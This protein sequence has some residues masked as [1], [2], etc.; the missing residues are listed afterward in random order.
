MNLLLQQDKENMKKPLL[1]LLTLVMCLSV[2]G[3][4]PLETALKHLEKNHERFDLTEG[5]VQ[6]LIV[7]DNYTSKHN[8]VQHIYLQQQ[9]KGI[10]VH[11]AIVNINVTESGKVLNTGNRFV[12]HL[13]KKINTDLPT[14]SASQAVQAAAR[15]LELNFADAIN[16]EK[17][18]EGLTQKTVL[19][20]PDL[21][22]DPIPAELVYQPFEEDNSVR[23]AWNLLI[24]T[25][26]YKDAWNVR[27]DAMTGEL[28]DKYNQVIHCNFGT[29]DPSCIEHGHHHFPPVSTTSTA[30]SVP[31]DY[32][33]YAFPIE[34]PIHGERSIVNSPWEA[35]GPDASP[36]GWHSDGNADFTTTRGNNV[37]AQEDR[38]GND[39]FGYSPE[40]P[41]LDFN[42]PLD[43]NLPPSEYQDAAITNLF[44]WCN[45]MHDVWYQYGFDEPSGNFQANNRDQ[46]G[47][48]VDAIQADAQDGSGTNNANFQSGGDG[49]F[50]RI[51]MFEWSN[52]NIVPP[53]NISF[54]PIISGTYNGSLAGFDPPLPLDPLEGDVVVAY[55]AS[56][57]PTWCCE[58]IANADEVAGNIALI[59][60]GD[61]WFVEK[62][63]NA[64]DAGAIAVIIYNNEPGNGTIPLGAPDGFAND[65]NIPAIMIGNNDAQDILEAIDLGLPV[66]VSLQGTPHSN[67]PNLDGDLD[68]GIISHEY[69]HGL[70]IRMTGGPSSGGC[71]G[72]EEQMGE[73]WSDWFGLM[74]TMT[75]EHDRNTPRGYGTYASSQSIDGTG[76]REAPYTT[77]FAINNYTYGATNNPNL[78]VP[79]SIGFV[80]ATIL[81]EAT[82]DMIDMYGFDPDLHN[83][84]GGNNI[85]M[86]LVIDGIKL[87]PCSPGFIDGRDA[88]LLA[89]EINYGGEHVCMLWEAFA[90]RG[91]GGSASQGNSSSRFDQTEAFDIGAACVPNIRLSME[92]S[93]DS[94]NAG[95]NI[96]YTFTVTNEALQAVTGTHIDVRIPDN[97]T[98]VEGSSEYP[99]TVND[100]MVTLTI[101]DMADGAVAVCNMELTADPSV[102]TSVLLMDPMETDENW[103]TS[104]GGFSSE[105]FTL[106][107]DN[108][109]TGEFAWFARDIETQ[110]DQYLEINEPLSIGSNLA[111]PVLSFWHDYDTEA[112]WDGG[113]VEYST[114]GNNWIDMGQYMVQNGYNSVIQT[115]PDSEISDREAFSGQSDGYINTLIDVSSFAGQNIY[116]RFRFASDGYVGG[117]GWYVDQ[118]DI[119]DAAFLGIEACAQADGFPEICLDHTAVVV[120]NFECMADAGALVA[121]DEP[122]DGVTIIDILA[123]DPFITF[124]AAYDGETP[125]MADYDRMYILTEDNDPTYKIKQYNETGEFNLASLDPA[126]YVVWH[127]AYSTINPLGTVGAFINGNGITSMEVFQTKANEQGLCLSWTNQDADGN[128]M[129]VEVQAENTSLLSVEN[130]FDIKV[131][132]VPT[133]DILNVEF[134]ADKSENYQLK[135]FNVTGQLVAEQTL[136]VNTG[137]NQVSLSVQAYTAGIYWLSIHND[138]GLKAHTR[139]VKE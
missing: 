112:S 89:D 120:S 56:T 127:V 65:L 24:R 12:N 109:Y 19:N 45:L 100:D 111:N 80:W 131:A 51:Q 18:E 50:A 69:G 52:Q 47:I 3:Q 90:R 59:E 48:G 1:I 58:V 23:L 137:L 123:Q 99:A 122:T 138:A 28:L 72:N 115:N 101:G 57:N 25:T 68:G 108:V 55:D 36:F 77:N 6:D 95:E 94:V 22:L 121:P 129:K 83:G 21:S 130:D 31:N 85:M 43:F 136:D 14:L 35:A 84:T 61:C 30:A 42:Y 103:S 49:S 39:G 116:V 60:R 135:V 53:L 107:T 134:A 40:S 38:N 87:Q 97:A 64:E 139:F 74:M 102:F 4:N 62:I 124:D 15:H 71:L 73:G 86:Q 128:V 20:V 2:Y 63:A 82:W 88:I 79:H 96:G 11:N 70:S 119:L 93:T 91:L 66:S 44:Y 126:T 125:D 67:L 32:N 75:A 26:D 133:T 92:A 17:S 46:G 29:P 78:F 16:V 105:N 54:P 7:R 33:V 81:W 98:Y 13:T 118:V 5:D 114:N 117:N 41:T 76:I 132:P 9:H 34:S 110:S 37:R 10:P 106:V 113:V 8:G 27:I 104:N